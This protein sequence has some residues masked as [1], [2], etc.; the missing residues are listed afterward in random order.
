MVEENND[1]MTENLFGKVK[2]LKSVNIFPLFLISYQCNFLPAF[3]FL[4]KAN[5]KIYFFKRCLFEFLK[6]NLKKIIQRLI[7]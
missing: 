7:L 5:T 4:Y 2:E 1:Q 3:L 6:C